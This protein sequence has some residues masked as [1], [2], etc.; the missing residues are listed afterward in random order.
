MVLWRTRRSTPKRCVRVV[1]RVCRAS[2]CVWVA[3]RTFMASVRTAKA[4][5]ARH[6]AASREASILAANVAKA[7][8]HGWPVVLTLRERPPR[9]VRGRISARRIDARRKMTGRDGESNLLVVIEGE[10]ISLERISEIHR[11]RVEA[12]A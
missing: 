11:Q 10:E 6:G 9:K 5:S 3:G 1:A 4:A 7:Q 2:S 8:A 12:P